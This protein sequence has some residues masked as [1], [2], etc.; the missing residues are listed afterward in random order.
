M[1]HAL[2]LRLLGHTIGPPIRHCPMLC[3]LTPYLLPHHYIKKPWRLYLTPGTTLPAHF[4]QQP[5]AQRRNARGSTETLTSPNCGSSAGL[6]RAAD[7]ERVP[8]H[9]RPCEVVR[10]SRVG[11]LQGE[12]IIA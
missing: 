11:P 6:A 4:L 7:G 1:G 12:L 8:R 3:R 5:M 9:E 10:R 2:F